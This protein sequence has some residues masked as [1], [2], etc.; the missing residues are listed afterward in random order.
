MKRAFWEIVRDRGALV[1]AILLV[2]RVVALAMGP[3]ILNGD[4]ILYAKAAQF[5]AETGLAP[6]ASFQSRTYS[7]LIAPLVALLGEAGRA[8]ITSHANHAIGSI[9]H[10]FQV[11]LDLGVILVLLHVF[12][13]MRPRNVWA[14]RAGLA[15]IVLQPITACWT[16]FM[17]PD[18][19]ATAS[20][21]GGLWLVVRSAGETIDWRRLAL[22]SL[23]C[24]I[25]GLVRVDMALLA[26]A[27]LAVWLLVV[28]WP[29]GVAAT[30]RGVTVSA[31]LF[32]VPIVAMGAYQYASQGSVRYIDA[33]ARDNPSVRKP[34]YFAWTRAWVVTPGD[35]KTFVLAAESGPDWAGYDAAAYPGRAFA[36]PQDRAAAAPA[37]AAW[38]AQGYTPAVDA[39]LANASSRLRGTR[40]AQPYLAAA[41][42]TFQ[43][44][45]NPDGA[46][47]LVQGLGLQPPWSK[48]AAAATT[49][50]KTLLALLALLGIWLT[51]RAVRR[52]PRAAFT[53]YPTAFVT[54]AVLTL[55]FRWIEMFVLNLSI[56]GA[57]MESRYVIETWPGLIALAGL[58]WRA[59]ANRFSVESAQIPARAVDTPEPV[60]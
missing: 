43:L 24:G 14:Y 44:W 55:V 47:A 45:A 2:A 41:L 53:D 48:L 57:G 21:V 56:G 12:A 42:R 29:R 20:F 11:L 32:L 58:G 16:N 27:V 6:P 26:V 40:P 9:V 23:L 51:L 50:L 4:G 54:L 22:G 39:A 49:A 8:P 7:V 28:F 5:V 34:G 59:V 60:L 52:S 1:I 31:A 19:I 3:G 37:F 36:S 33:S 25:S 15:V 18:T 13:A 46:A 10:L 17:V 30:A 35:F 38:K